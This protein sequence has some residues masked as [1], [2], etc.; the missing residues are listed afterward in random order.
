MHYPYLPYV[1]HI[2]CPPD[3]PRFGHPCNIRWTAQIMKFLI[4]LLCN[5]LLTF[6]PVWPNI[7]PAAPCSKAPSLWCFAQCDRPSF[8]L[9]P[10]YIMLQTQGQTLGFHKIHISSLLLVQLSAFHR[11]HYRVPYLVTYMHATPRSPMGLAPKH[12]L[13]LPITLPLLHL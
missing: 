4:T 5:L 12:P 13:L 3:P 6:T 2:S 11:L 9:I 7:F 1:L 8:A 10:T